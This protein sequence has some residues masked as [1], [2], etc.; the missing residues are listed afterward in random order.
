MRGLLLKDFQLTL[1]NKRLIIIVIVISA[2]FL[3]MGDD[4]GTFIIGYVTMI[5]AMQ[6]LTTITYD[7]FDKSN[8]FLLTLPITRKSYVIEK[9]VFGICCD[10]IG[11][12]ISSAVVTIYRLASRFEPNWLDWTTGSIA[13]LITA[14]II[15]CLA[16]PIQLKFGGEN[17]RIVVAAVIIVIAVGFFLAIKLSETLGVDFETVAQQL[18]LLNRG[19]LVV[20]AAAFLAVLFGVSIAV[21]TRM[22]RKKEF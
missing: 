9:Y 4:M 22:M 1:A 14:L 12:G 7:D 18:L 17:G 21:S 13:I 15:I 5:F 8:K 11:W 20:I 19:A 6:V 10:L 3:I 16:I 2:G